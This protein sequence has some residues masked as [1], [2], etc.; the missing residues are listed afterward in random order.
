MH[1]VK[2]SFKRL[3]AV[4]LC[5]S[6]VLSNGMLSLAE[7]AEDKAVNLAL[8]CQATANAQYNQNGNDMS[9]SK[10][11]DGNDETR[12][13]SEG[14]APGWLQVDLGEQKSFTQFRI[15]SEGGTGVTVGKQLIGKFKIEGSND[16]S[17]WTL[18]HQSEDKQA[19]GFPQDTV[20]TLE[21]PVS[22]RYVK[23]TV[24]SLKTGAFDSVSIREYEIRDKEETTP[25]KPQDPEE[26]V[27]LKKTAAADST[28]DNSLIAAKA[29][30]GNTKDRSSRW[31]SAVADAPHWIYVDL[32]KEMDVKT[33][34]IFWETRKATDYKIQIANTAEA[35]A[36][37]DW[38][39]VK[40]VQDR[41][42]ALKDA[43]VLD[44]VEK[45]RYVRLYINSFTKNDPDNEGAS[46]NS[47]S[48]YEM[49][50]YGGEPKV[51]IEEG[52]SVDTPK[53]GDKKLTVHIPEE[54]KTEKVTYNGTDY[55]QVVDADLNLYQPVV[56][57]T[58]K[59][60]FKIENKENGSYRFKEIPV[61]VPGEYETKE[62]DNAAPDVLP[63]IR[64][65]KGN[66]GTFAPNAGSRIVIKD[67]E[68]QEMAD[69]FAKD[70]EAIMG[71]TLPVVTADSANAGDFFFA[72]T[73]EGKGLQEE[74]YLMTVDE[75][76]AVEAETTT[77]AFW[78][79][80]TILQSL[81]ANGNIP[82]GVARDYPLYKVRGFFLDVGR[83]TFTMDWLEDTV[84]QMS[85]YKMND[86][87]IHLNDNLI[88]L[89]HYSQIGEDP[90]QAYS[91]FRLESD[92][93]EGGKDGLYK[94]D[95]T[96][97]D[98]FYTKDEFRNLIQESRVYGVDIVPEIDTPAHSLALTKVRPDLRHG[99]YGRDNDHLALKEKYDES[100]E[101]VQSIFNE[102][103]GKDL[104]DP[105]F[106][107]DTVVH[108]GADEY[109]AAPEAYRKFADDML[110][111]VQDSGRTPRI[112]GS[113]S[114]I[115]GET[116]VRSE[117]VQMNLWNFGWAN[118]DKMYE[119]GYDLINCNDGNYYI[120][121][122]AGYYYDYLNEDTL[123]NLAINS[124][125]GVTIPAGD[126]QMIGGAI[127]VWNDMT[128]YLEN[129]VSEYDVYDRIDNEI[130]LF[131]AK[132]W[133]KGNKDLSA[134]KEDYAALGTA[135]RTNFTYETE[136]NEEGAAVHYPM[137]NMKDASGSGQDLK[138]GKNAAIESVDGRNALKLE[139]KESYVSTDLATA[140]LG[141]DL[142]VK[143]KRTT[144][145]DEEQI[146]FE[147][148]YGTIKAVQ[149]ETGKV[150]FTREN[151]DYSFNYKLPVNE[152]VELEFKNE[153]NKTYLYVNGELRDVLGDDE[154][155]EGRPLLATTMFPIERIG[156]TKNAF[157]GYVDDVRLGTNAD[158]ASTMPL[159]YAVLTANQVIGKTEN[160]QLAQL[161][162]EA[163]A[164][165]AAYNPDA[166]AINDLAAE[167]KAVLDD[168][169]YKEADYSRIETLK[170]T[171]PSDLSPFTEESAAWL[172][173]V[174]SQIR[175]G[176]PEEMQSTVDGYEKMLADALAGLTLVE[177][178]NV[179]YVD[180]A[181]LTATAS[182][183]QD[184]GSAPDKALDGDTNTIWHSKWDITTMPHWIDLEME[185]PMAV[186]GL[187]Y[188][189]R[190]TGTNGNVTK[191]EIQISN[192]GTNYTKHAEG[193]LKNN[194]DTKVIDFNKV[195]T[196]H[197]RLVYL[198][199]ANNNGAAA[200]LKLHQADV[201]ADIEGLTA[202]IT[203]AKAIKNEGFTKESWDALQ[204]KIAEAEE[205][206]SAEN[207]D[208]N[209][210][211]IMKR[212]L[213][214]AMTSLI[215]EDK[216]TSDPEPGKVDKS[217]LQELYN[218]YKGIK[219]DGYTAESWTAFAEARTEAETVL[220]NEKATQEKV[221]KAAENLEKAF[222]SLKKEET[223]PDPDPTP[224]P[225]PGAADVSGLKNLYEAY[226]DIKSD[227]YTAES[228]AAFD[229]ARAEAE[230]ILANP[231]ATQ[232]DVNAAKAALEA[233]YK[234][235]VP[236]TQ[237][238][239]TPGGNGGNVGSTAV[240]TGDSANI[241]GY[242][243]VLLAAGG[244][245]VV[246]FFRRK[247]V[248]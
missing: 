236:K 74:G 23:L 235:L 4:S 204:N 68:L 7:G 201:P 224:D 79:T 27:A 17:K 26:N 125:G 73:K 102:Y 136:K 3:L 104:S 87:Q 67:A 59:V 127:A 152:W 176:L 66:A 76:T 130:A 143:V 238:N 57:T 126:K 229:K 206:A 114:T 241:A 154:R 221:D 179:N 54:T 210:V 119:Q 218:K 44:K 186:D 191:Y 234:G 187:T 246:T 177:E 12:W 34:C 107:K 205:L 18:I 90:M 40:H 222:K 131:G 81:K 109:T 10:A 82:Q 178:R 237:P 155:V 9:A 85:W 140:G 116:S 161:V 228:W 71:Q 169:D 103:M 45:A 193:T 29:F 110:K 46:W 163:E 170:K 96:S 75:K 14:A 120:V 8:G 42:K 106:D 144:D 80:R 225:D 37:S 137:D 185:E 77:G 33:V 89:E 200:E 230:K 247:R 113:L 64:E 202:V 63:E 86:F 91:A 190:Q 123:Y 182:S 95:L 217:K 32:G 147:S 139:G 157:T 20:V 11:V 53:K 199:A 48:I 65:W 198:E 213:S 24:E 47:I 145:G 239:P 49:E 173:Y 31:S 168:S 175:T 98:V 92:I 223:K 181:K 216:V 62:G 248:K 13:S 184:N 101:F 167:I 244:I 122:N 162:K 227:G 16:N 105:V 19:E 111:Y 142:R 188:V 52:I 121:P 36:E 231:N 189:P 132:L 100:L 56:D 135:P 21:K 172:E 93:K 99:T 84:K 141:N 183:H 134:A 51:D 138:E 195:T 58:V 212:E 207:A 166:S 165:F 41:P 211:E 158:F 164:I 160:A 149:K 171:I 226:K 129:G 128:D 232:D 112:W 214:K 124:I 117:G 153:Q 159:D 61:T 180:N 15:L 196:K 108:V 94:A 174:L 219:A 38:K 208:A 1:N 83:K 245:A 240:V 22:Y 150:G 78:A 35:P 25:E 194:A 156:S 60:S 30:D 88:P 5:A 115:K 72:L 39:D 197:V 148:S 133:G 43:I 242:L 233:A 70:Y 2:K 28:E 146:L 220:A 215:L 97:K 50:V 192:D 118:M 69:A 55:E 203:E 6:C 209:D 243:T 151:H